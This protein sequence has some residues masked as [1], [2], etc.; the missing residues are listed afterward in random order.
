MKYFRGLFTYELIIPLNNDQRRL[1]LF[2]A[3]RDLDFRLPVYWDIAPSRCRF[4][5]QLFDTLG[6]EGCHSGIGGFC[7]F[8]YIMCKLRFCIY[9]A[10]I[11]SRIQYC[12]EAY[13]SCAKESL[14]KLQIMQNK[15]LKS[16]LK[17]D[18][19]TPTNLVHQRLSILKIDDV[20]IAKVLSF[21]NECRSCRVPKMLVNYYK[22]RETGLNLR[23]RSSL[24]IPWARTDL[25]LSRCDIKG[26]R[27][28]NNHLQTS[29]QLLYKNNFHKQ[30]R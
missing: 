5:I 28:W 16:L 6:C 3:C 24:D 30:F 9:Y 19:R 21:V 14:S 20:Y 15:L 25:G 17:W 1:V 12:I 27:L 26:A 18:R 23:N 8:V 10:F 13:G 7:Y 11:Y 22:F 2:D 4:T 29:S